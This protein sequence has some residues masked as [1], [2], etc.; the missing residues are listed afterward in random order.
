MG[1][2]RILSSQDEQHL[3]QACPDL[4]NWP[5][6]WRYDDSDIALGQ[7]IV[8]VLTPFLLALMDEG[9]AR[10]TL[11]RHRDN[12][13]LL[14]GETIRRRYEDDDLAR[15]DIVTALRRLIDDEGGPFMLPRIS[16]AEQTSLDATCRKLHRFLSETHK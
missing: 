6:S 12:L 14:G 13:W 9:L 5:R 3:R 7:Q 16:E 2:A 10:A 4:S 11:R 8:N 1:S 15:Q